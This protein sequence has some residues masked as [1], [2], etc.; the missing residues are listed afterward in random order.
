MRAH[1][2]VVL[3]EEE[4]LSC[5]ISSGRVFMI[6]TRAQRKLLHS[7]IIVK[8]HLVRIGQMHGPTECLSSTLVAIIFGVCGL[9]S[10]DRGLKL[11]VQG[12]GQSL[13]LGIGDCLFGGGLRF[14]V[15]GLGVGVTGS[16]SNF[17]GIE[18]R[19]RTGLRV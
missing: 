5:A 1:D 19:V 6:N 7:C 16:G 10:E 18:F 13:G 8:H 14:V 12:L 9:W 2:E 3:H 4:V 11:V 17:W 15:C